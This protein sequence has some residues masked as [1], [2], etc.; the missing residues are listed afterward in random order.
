[1]IQAA[2]SAQQDGWSAFS[3]SRW[4]SAHYLSIAER[5]YEFFSCARFPG[6]DPTEFC[7]N[8]GWLPAFP[9]LIRFF[10]ALNL[11]PVPSG[12]WIA[13]GFALATLLLLWNCFLGPQVSAA[14]LLSLALA[15]FFP[16]HVYHHAMFPVSICSFFQLLAI[17]AYVNQRFAWAGA[18]GAVASFSYSS[19][20]FLAGVFAL[21]SLWKNR[22]Q[23][24][25]HRIGRGALT[26]GLVAA[27]FVAFLIMLHF[28]VGVWRGYFLVQAK[29]GYGPHMPW[30]VLAGHLRKA[31]RAAPQFQTLLVLITVCCFVW[32]AWR[33]PRKH[34]DRVL[35]IFSVIYWLIPLCLGGNLSLYRAEAML[36]PGVPLSAKLPLPVL[37]LLLLLALVAASKVDVLFFRNV[38]V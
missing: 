28:E 16:G 9:L 19:G 36:L 37:I 15:A 31:L 8:T 34:L 30:V 27:G 35:V 29:Y 11:P 18:A 20:V 3:Y 13:G 10:T 7:G 6:Y 2:A 12:A 21:D 32:A 38:L 23:P 25:V 4:D 1:M 17:W 33:S 22:E 14:G 24:L 5:G 26:S